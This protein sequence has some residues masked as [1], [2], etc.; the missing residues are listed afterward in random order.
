MR[1]VDGLVKAL[2]PFPLTA[3]V[4]AAVASPEKAGGVTTVVLA[5]G[6]YGTRTSEPVAEAPATES[7]RTKLCTGSDY[8]L[9]GMVCLAVT[10]LALQWPTLTLKS[11]LLVANIHKAVASGVGGPPAVAARVNQCLKTLVALQ[12]KEPT[13]EAYQS[14]WFPSER[15]TLGD[16]INA[17]SDR[18]VRNAGSVSDLMCDVKPESAVV[19]RHLCQAGQQSMLFTPEETLSDV[20]VAILGRHKLRDDSHSFIQRLNNVQQLTGLNDPI[21]VEASVQVHHFDIILELLVINRTSSLLQNITLEFSTQRE[22]KVVDRPQ[23]VTLSP[24]EATTVFAS[25]KA[26]ASD[27]G[28]IYGHATFEHKGVTREVV[29]L[30]LLKVELLTA[31]DLA[32]TTELAFRSM[33]QECE[34]ENKIAISTPLTDVWELMRLLI[35]RTKMTVVGRKAPVAG[36]ENAALQGL[37]DSPLF[38]LSRTSHFYAFNLHGRTAFGEDSLANVAIEVM[39]DGKL[40]GSIRIRTRSQGVA[41]TL[42]EQLVEIQRSVSVN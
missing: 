42:G 11:L 32:W 23:P 31:V 28:V 12:N 24:G 41:L 27:S 4:T 29:P 33:W 34:W 5:D 37:K 19:F 40:S 36:D 39:A 2:E 1:S 10:R 26:Q 17:N 14:T 16:V 30:G 15:E 13:L 6:T 35:T 9:T 38:R 20:E 18:P 7:L 21:Y 22:I 25:L 8:L 3:A